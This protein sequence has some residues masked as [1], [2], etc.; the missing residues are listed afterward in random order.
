MEAEAGVWG[1]AGAVQK[2]KKASQ[3]Y[4]SEIVRERTES[5]FFAI[6]AMHERMHGC[7]AGRTELGSWIIA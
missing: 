1:E 2:K 3:L 6:E 4:L 5:P 7:T